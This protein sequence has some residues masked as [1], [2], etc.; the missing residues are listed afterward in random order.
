MYFFNNGDFIITLF[1]NFSSNFKNIYLKLK[2]PYTDD[3][4]YLAVVTKNGL[5][6][7]DKIKFLF[8]LLN[9]FIH[10]FLIL[11]VILYI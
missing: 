5:W 8:I 2:S 1:Y 3:G 6:I 4:K 7:R 11:I 9:F 10:I